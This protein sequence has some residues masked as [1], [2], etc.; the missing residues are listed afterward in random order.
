MQELILHVDGMMCSHCEARVTKA[1]SELAGVQSTA[2]NLS[3][4]TVTVTFDPAAVTAQQ[5]RDAITEQGYDV[6]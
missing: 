4:K 6:A 1:V 5:I 3:D 2:V